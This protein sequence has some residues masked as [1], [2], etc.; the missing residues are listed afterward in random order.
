M[1]D[2]NPPDQHQMIFPLEEFQKRIKKVREKMS[3]KGIDVLLIDCVEHMVYLF[4]YAPPAA[5]YQVVLLPTEGDPIGVIRA[6][7]QTTFDEQSWVRE[8]VFFSD[9]ENPI[10]V[11][12]KTVQSKGWSAARFGLELDSHFL[13]AKR[14]LQ[15][16]RALPDCEFDDFSQILREM[17][18][19]KSPLEIKLMREVSRIADAGMMAAID[20]AGE[21][22]NERQ[23]AAELYA[24][25][26][27]EGAD[28]TRSALMSA[29]SR[30][31]SL[32]GRLGNHVMQ[33]GDVL[34]TE[35]IPLYF[36][37]GAR[38]MRSTVIGEP[39]DELA[40]AAGTMIKVQEDQYAAMV[41]GAKAGEVDSILRSGI[42]DAGL[43]T[44][45]ENV[46][47]YTMG[48]IGLPVT[49]DFTR[50]FAP[51]ATWTLEP[52]MVFHMYTYAT[53]I[54]FSDTIMITETGSE[55]LTKTDRKLFIR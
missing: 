47:G 3:Q 52:G 10:E 36:G 6:L 41:P 30:S 50:A 31:D 14:F 44:N 46:T 9:F 45:Y 54:A 28:S 51:G 13:P 48:F 17:R 11:I 21:G 33:R 55:R 38:L 20:T 2:S 29:G 4:G 23:C 43:R 40:Q 15:L 12:A 37:Y 8:T 42:L 16:E 19:I 27:A 5:I 1:T 32:H 25:V 24:K 53:G 26:I 49:S 18:L 7:D 39:T 35:S 22:V 34:H